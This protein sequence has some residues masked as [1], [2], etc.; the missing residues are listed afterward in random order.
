M[1]VRKLMTKKAIAFV[2]AFAMVATMLSG[3]SF[4]SQAADDVDKTPVYS[5]YNE[6][7]GDHVY[8]IGDD[9]QKAISYGLN[10]ENIS[11]YAPTVSLQPVFRIYNPNTGE[12]LFTRDKEAG[13]KAVDAGWQWDNNGEA[14]LYSNDDEDTQVAVYRFYHSGVTNA[15]SHVYKSETQTDDIAK[16]YEMGYVLEPGETI[17]GVADQSAAIDLIDVQGL[18]ADGTAKPTDTLQIVFGSEYGVPTRVAWYHNGAVAKVVTS[19]ITSYAFQL[20]GALDYATTTKELPAGSYYAVVETANK[21]YRT[22]DLVVAE[23]GVAV[24][25]DFDLTDAY[26]AIEQTR[27]MP[28]ALA[29][30]SSIGIVTVTLNKDYDGVFYLVNSEVEKKAG[31]KTTKENGVGFNTAT[32]STG[33]GLVIDTTKAKEFTNDKF[34]DAIQADGVT[35]AGSLTNLPANKTYAAKYTAPDG[36]VTY[37]FLTSL[38]NNS[39][40]TK[41]GES[42]Y[43]IFDQDNDVATGTTREDWNTTD[44]EKFEYVMAPDTLEVTNIQA[45]TGN[46]GW[47]ATLSASYLGG[48][49]TGWVTGYND[50][51][52]GVDV[53]LYTSSKNDYSERQSFNPDVSILVGGV[54]KNQTMA[55]ASKPSLAHGTAGQTY[56][57]AT[58][59]ADA[60]IFGEDALTLVSPVATT[61]DNIVEGAT[62][63]YDYTKAPTAMT[64]DLQKLRG[65]AVAYLV[66][67]SKKSDF[68]PDKASTYNDFVLLEKGENQALIGKLDEKAIGETFDL[69]IVPVDDEQF[70][71]YGEKFDN[72]NLQQQVSAESALFALSG[73]TTGLSNTNTGSAVLVTYNQFGKVKRPGEST[74][75]TF[76]GATLTKVSDTSP[77]REGDF[78]FAIATDGKIS[79][80]YTTTVGCTKGDAWKFK[81][82]PYQYLTFTCT[83]TDG[84]AAGTIFKVTLESK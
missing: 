70:A 78:K 16:L 19:D 52:A 55:D 27:P 58:C 68:D 59:E 13:Q 11:W 26:D 79:T 35:F 66:D 22:N 43:L 9:V 37:K 46:T 73:T 32:A 29:E 80:Q 1:K 23:E 34:F 62:L 72:V 77:A 5:F 56:V 64:I 14:Y 74:R 17:Y 82:T 28:I 67:D 36:T 47:T 81:L 3:I 2:M 61:L 6:H 4:A 69:V 24:L 20:S 38:E 33:S 49:A 42:Y 51:N 31:V 54:A 12:H 41:R 84:T 40:K 18:Q 60:G 15:S 53:K 21:T 50:G 57:F 39:Q 63:T 48:Q 75:G 25:S 8:C 71:P 44:D 30:D 76:V 83:E 7:N 65:D 45:N 10:N